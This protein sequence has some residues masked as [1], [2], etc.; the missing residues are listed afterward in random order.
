MEWQREKGKQI[1]RNVEICFDYRL[2]RLSPMFNW[3]KIQKQFVEDHR[4]RQNHLSYG[5][6]RLSAFTVEWTAFVVFTSSLCQG[7]KLWATQHVGRLLPMPLCCSG[8]LAKAAW[9]RD[10]LV[11]S[12]QALFGQLR[13]K[14]SSLQSKSLTSFFRCCRKKVKEKSL[15]PRRLQI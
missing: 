7:S 9:N 3:Q 4:R 10:I 8:K 12:E 2:Y 5:F 1:E 11:I 13:T 15:F 6:L 14:L